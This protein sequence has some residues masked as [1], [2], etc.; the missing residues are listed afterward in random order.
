[1]YSALSPSGNF[2]AFTE[3][4]ALFRRHGRLIYELAKREVRERYSG[5]FFGLL[6]AFGHPLLLMLIYV[7]I[8]AF[9]FQTRVGGTI[10]MPLDYTSYM[11][12]GLI[13]WLAFQESL[14]KASTVIVSNANVVKQVI[15]PLEVLP[16]KSV[17]AT[18]FSELVFLALL[19]IYTLIMV[20]HLN[21]MYLLL[22]F[23]LIIQ[24]AWM[25]GIAYVLSA[26]GPYFRDIKDFVQVF[27]SIAFFLLPI[28]YLPTAIPT[29]IRIILYIN[30]FSYLI[31]CS[32][33]I[34]YF[35]SFSHPY[36]WIVTFILSL[37]SFVV[38]YRVFRKLKVMFGNVL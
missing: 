2:Q 30:P 36:A 26:V 34:L 11:L 29:A 16:I 21:W 27:N 6:W 37:L 22:P 10:D 20:G 8:F 15:F 14:M 13:P 12:A 31:W 18:V 5:Q 17:L 28:L 33:D 9:V 35:G 4:T 24:M 1:M 3:L 25:I 23:L 32:Q 38:G 7:F 19:M